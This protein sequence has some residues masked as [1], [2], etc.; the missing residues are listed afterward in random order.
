MPD[1]PLPR[2]LG[3][4]APGSSLKGSD[5]PLG[6]LRPRH[7]DLDATRGSIAL[8]ELSVSSPVPCPFQVFVREDLGGCSAPSGRGSGGPCLRLRGRRGTRLA[9]RR[10]AT[11]K[12]PGGRPTRGMARAPR[13]VS[14]RLPAG[15]SVPR[16]TGADASPEG[17]WRRHR[18]R[19]RVVE[20][21]RSLGAWHGGLT[22]RIWGENMHT[23]HG[24]VSATTSCA[25]LAALCIATI[26][27]DDLLGGETITGS[28]SSPPRPMTSAT[29]PGSTS[30][31]PST[32]RS[33]R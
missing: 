13:E 12:Q 8:P 22:R 19:A 20:R 30:A 1:G 21:R 7:E 9:Q 11:D 32:L 28:G 4:Q 10:Q 14:I 18:E 24:T 15:R 3:R 5:R 27:C 26:S 33:R 31:T 6:R 25:L 23:I 29:S 17:P 16:S 2:D